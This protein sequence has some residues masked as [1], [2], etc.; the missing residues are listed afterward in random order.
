MGNKSE[1]K[2]IDF[3]SEPVG[4]PKVKL[5]DLPEGWQDNLLSMGSNGWADVEMRTELGICEQLFNR[6]VD[7]EP[8]FSRAVQYARDLSRKWWYAKGRKLA[9]GE[10]N[11]S[12]Y[13]LRMSSCHD[14]IPKKKIEVDANVQDRR[15][16]EK[17]YQMAKQLVIER[18]GEND[19]SKE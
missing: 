16:P 2:M 11:T 5:E 9:H 3:L 13:A 10:I 1:F 17:E 19:E 4:R 7:E 12:L 14:M 15:D 18:E 6:L 8:E